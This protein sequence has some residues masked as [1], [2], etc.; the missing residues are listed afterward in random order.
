M[1]NRVSQKS[2]DGKRNRGNIQGDENEVSQDSSL[3]PLQNPSNS[4][5]YYLL[6]AIGVFVAFVAA[7]VIWRHIR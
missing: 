2:Q 1:K 3:N 5:A 4:T 7:A 6:A